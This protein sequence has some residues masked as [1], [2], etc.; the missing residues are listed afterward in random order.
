VRQSRCRIR[1]MPSA[2]TPLDVVGPRVN[3]C[4]TSDDLCLHSHVSCVKTSDPAA[5]FPIDPQQRTVRQSMM[6]GSHGKGIPGF[7]LFN[8]R[9]TR[10]ADSA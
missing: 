3:V 5:P 10:T 8:T 1:L 9:Q 4:V 2:P 6:S 7:V